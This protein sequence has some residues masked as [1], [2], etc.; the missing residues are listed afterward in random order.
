M[1]T[2]AFALLAFIVAACA[3]ESPTGTADAGTD[4]GSDVA[5]DA[6]TDLGTD[7]CT[8]SR[9]LSIC[10]CVLGECYDEFCGPCTC[11]PDD[12]GYTEAVNG[13]DV[14]W[15]NRTITVSCEEDRDPSLWPGVGDDQEADECY[16]AEFGHYPEF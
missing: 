4:L 13:V 12:P 2:L 15:C 8:Q 14:H 6:G 7:A 3:D 11:T 1:R 9:E 5:S 10:A 16:R